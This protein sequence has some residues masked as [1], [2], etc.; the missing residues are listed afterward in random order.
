[1]PT[2]DNVKHEKRVDFC[3]ALQAYDRPTVKLLR[4]TARNLPHETV[5]HTEFDQLSTRPIFLSIEA[6]GSD[7]NSTQALYQMSTWLSAHWIFLQ[8]LLDMKYGK[9]QAS[10]A[11]HQMQNHLPFLPGIIISGH[12]WTFVTATRGREREEGGRETDIW[13]G[14]HLGSTRSLCGIAQIIA[15]LQTLAE[16]SVSTYW[17][18]FKELISEAGT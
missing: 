18:W 4:R 17:P 13:T 9:G 7:G 8:S 15:S 14:I 10:R 12:D 1:M 3:L 2:R 11:Q 6:K 5:N 16:W